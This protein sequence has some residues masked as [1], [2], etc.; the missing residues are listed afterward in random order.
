M[1][2]TD[3]VSYTH[4]DVYKRQVYYM[5]RKIDEEYKN[6]ELIVNPSKKESLVVGNLGNNLM[7]GRPSV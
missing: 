3:S 4:L 1:K 2:T 7:L 6:C 5:L